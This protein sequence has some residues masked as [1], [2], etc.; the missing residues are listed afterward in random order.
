MAEE[1]G[2]P[3]GPQPGVLGTAGRPAR[4]MAA[5]ARGGLAPPPRLRL[6]ASGVSSR[7]A[8]SPVRRVEAAGGQVR[9]LT[10][11][12][13][14]HTVLRPEAGWMGLCSQVRPLGQDELAWGKSGEAPAESRGWGGGE[15]E[16]ELALGRTKPG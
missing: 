6:G 13:G 3:R 12:A 5:R 9:T 16:R 8:G 14:A 4:G 7:D 11:A 15:T 10:G 2:R 1:P